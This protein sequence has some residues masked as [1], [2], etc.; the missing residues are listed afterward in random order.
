MLDFRKGVIILLIEMIRKYA[1]ICDAELCHELFL[2]IF[3]DD[4]N[5]HLL[6]PSV[7]VFKV[8]M[9][10]D[11]RSAEF[12]RIKVATFTDYTKVYTNDERLSI[13]NSFYF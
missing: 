6:P 9:P 1:R 5:I 7:V 13:G 4:C 2:V 8:N 12:W 3:G 11:L 10:S